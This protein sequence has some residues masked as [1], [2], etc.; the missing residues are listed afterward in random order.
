[1]KLTSAFSLSS[2]PRARVLAV[3]AVLAVLGTGAWIG[4]QVGPQGP[5][6]QPVTTAPQQPALTVVVTHPRQ[7]VWNQTLS[8]SGGVAAW[9]EAVIAA[10]IGGLRVTRMA[11]D[12]G[13]TV[14]GGQVVAELAQATIDA[15]VRQQQ[16]RVAVA[17]AARADAK[18]NADRA[19][20]VRQ[21]GALS[22]QQIDQY[23][24]A[25]QTADAN[26]ALAVAGLR[27]E[28]L[29][30]SQ[31]RIM[32]PDDGIISSRSVTLGSVVQ[33]GAEL[34]RLVRQGR[35]EW[36][37]EVTAA[38]LAKIQPAQQ[39][40]VRLTNGTSVKGT[41]RLAAPTLDSHSR[42][43][44]VYV[45]LLPGSSARAGMFATG[46]IRVG[47][48]AAMVLPASAIVLRDGFSYVFVVNDKDVVAQLKVET[49]RRQGKDVEILAGLPAD[50]RV[51]S[52]GG[53]FL[54][55]GDSVRVEPVSKAATLGAGS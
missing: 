9:Q 15:S 35:L 45:D 8:A 13:S 47:A 42:K 17:R 20:L 1:M 11:A 30:L 19:R 54:D 34:F 55:G 10:E 23:L 4:S 50:S 2:P 28:V 7:A 21:S 32:A 36:R 29:R 37:A 5:K 3:S 46:E 27:S 38:N 52:Q 14:H 6:A 24:T 26:L 18:A 12:V 41:V 53:A 40:K 48:S 33:P 51:V 16:A 25:E 43:A 22:A 44:L 39:V 31:T 49:G